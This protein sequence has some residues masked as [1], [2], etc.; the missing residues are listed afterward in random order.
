MRRASKRMIIT[1]GLCLLAVLVVLV[2][3]TV[4]PHLVVRDRPAT[5]AEVS[6]TV[7]YS[8]A[9]DSQWLMAKVGMPLRRGDQL[10]TVP[11]HGRAT[12]HLDNGIVGFSLEPDSLLTMTAG[13][14]VLRQAASDGVYLS[15]GSLFAIAQKELPNALTS[16]HVDTEAAEVAIESTMLVVQVLKDEPTTRVSSM[17]G[18]VRVRAKPNAAVLYRPDAQRL[19]ARE[20]VLSSNE[21]LLVHME[22]PDVRP[23]TLRGCLGRV[24]DAETGVGSE[25]IVVHVVGNPELFAI[26]GA[27][28]Y[29]AIASAPANS[30]LMAVGA[31]EEVHGDLE[32][33]L[34][35]GQVA[36]R[37]I[38]SMTQEGIAEARVVPIEHPMLATETGQDGSFAI[39]ELPMGTHSLTVVVDG[40][41]S[42]VAEVTVGPQ[43]LIT[44]PD[45][46]VMAER[47]IETW[48][49]PA[50]FKNFVQYP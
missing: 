2:G 1:L 15:H 12:V 21:T 23:S 19:S 32:L 28:G 6:G 38:D 41:V 25:G 5:I 34:D 11:P 43:M 45:I 20:A 40:Y 3:L 31:T 13:W 42:A 9:R 16:F 7:L 14:N 29:F 17:E 30:E 48:R 4:G 50:V 18:E 10:L 22:S 44:I 47:E 36:G 39:D 49:L 35:V 27:D 37:V 8:S 26:T 33:R 24:V 46:P